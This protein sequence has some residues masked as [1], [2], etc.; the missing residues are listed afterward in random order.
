MAERSLAH[1]EKIAWIRPIEGADNIELIGV[2]GWVL[3]AK[4]NEFKVDDLCVF[5]EIDSK[6]PEAEWSEFMRPKHFKVKTMKLGKFGVI[7]QGLALPLK[8]FEWWEKLDESVEQSHSEIRDKLEKLEVG[9]DVTELLGVTYS[10]QEDNVRKSKNG[11]P[12][13]K[14]KSMASRHKELFKKKPFRW[15]MKCAWGRKLL[16][17]FFGKKKDN[18]K[19]F[20]DWI[21]K[22]DETRIENAPFYLESTEPWI[23]TEKIDGTSSTY[24]I[25]YTNKKAKHGDFVVCSRNVRQRD[26]EQECWHEC[27]NVYWEMAEKYNIEHALRDIAIRHNSE[28]VVLQGETYGEG[29]Q[30][31]PYKLN[32][33]RF[34]AFNLIIKENRLD[35]IKAMEIL[36]EYDI[37]FVPIIDVNYYLPKDM[38]TFKLEADGKSMI[39]DVKREGFVYR[40][41]DGNQSFKNVS[42]EFLLKHNG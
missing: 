41:K 19:A 37:P 33:R 25:D 29:V 7:S 15:L 32:E 16:F 10:V 39:A 22:T 5:F 12:D 42:R 30:G 40:S 28:R 14:Y 24:A 3:I 26:E 1:I 38:E 17:F 34:A 21:K 36:K 4:K 8:A 2:L 9:T 6:L 18:P 11:D 31:N 13:A 20:P 35:S 27:G 23:K